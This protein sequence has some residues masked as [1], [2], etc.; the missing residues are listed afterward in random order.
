MSLKKYRI[1]YFLGNSPVPMVHYLNAADIG[2]AMFDFRSIY[3]KAY[4]EEIVEV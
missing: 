4:I 3:P 2:L 1:V